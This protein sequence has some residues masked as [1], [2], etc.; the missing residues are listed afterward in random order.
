ML[1]PPEE[2]LSE[3]ENT[4][5]YNLD[6]D[7]IPDETRST[8]KPL[9]EKAKTNKNAKEEYLMDQTASFL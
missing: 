8:K 6:G 4:E 7:E 2:E 1:D 5:N 9:S 3:N